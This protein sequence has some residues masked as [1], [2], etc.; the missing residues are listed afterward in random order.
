MKIKMAILSVIAVCLVACGRNTD[1]DLQEGTTLILASF[2]DNVYLKKQVELY[3]QTHNEYQIEIQRYER[4]EQMEEDGIL[5]LQRE[6]ASGKGPD[7]I[8]FG[9]RL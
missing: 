2:D 1:D 5:L 9:A 4:S 8:D 6:I 7:I 3:N